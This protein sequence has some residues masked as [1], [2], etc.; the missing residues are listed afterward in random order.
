MSGRPP[1]P[2]LALFFLCGFLCAPAVAAPAAAKHEFRWTPL[3]LSLHPDLLILPRARAVYGL[4]LSL[5]M[6]AA[7]KVRGFQVAAL[8]AQSRD[9]RGFQIGALRAE[10]RDVDGFQVALF[11]SALMAIRG[12]QVGLINNLKFEEGSERVRVYGFQIGSMNAARRVDGL[13]AGVVNTCYRLRGGQLGA[14]NYSAEVAAFQIGGINLIGLDPARD[15]LAKGLQIGL[16]N[17]TT[18]EFKGLQ[19]GIFNSC[20]RLRGVQIG[21]IN[22][23][24]H[25]NQPR[26]LLV[27]LINAGW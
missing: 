12:G 26:L 19:I 27:P 16:F 10:S 1:L 20:R 5:G 3:M 25:P 15:E 2:S 14:L 22:Y 9:V 4:E 7:Q 24:S 13:Q 17:L 18:T 23:V 6:S 8:W 11:P 21:L